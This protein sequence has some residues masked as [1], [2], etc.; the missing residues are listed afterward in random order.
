MLFVKKQK[1]QNKNVPIAINEW[2]SAYQIKKWKWNLWTKYHIY[3]QR[4]QLPSKN[5]AVV[6]FIIF[7]C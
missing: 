4:Y 5:I 7:L 6:L 3:G 1:K 2:N